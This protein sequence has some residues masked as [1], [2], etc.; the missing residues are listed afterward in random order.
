LQL[1]SLC[2][3]ANPIILETGKFIREQSQRLH[4]ITIEE[5]DINSLVSYV[6]REAEKQLVAELGKLLPD[7]GFLTEEDTPNTEGKTWQWI[8]D[9]LD[10]TTNFLYGIPCFS[11]SVGLK[12]DDKLVLG[13]IYEINDDEL[14]YAWEN[15]GAFLN[16]NRIHVSQRKLLSQ[17]LLATGF[18]YYDFTSMGKYLKSFTYLM[19]NSR[20]IRRLGSAA[21]DLAYVAC[22]RFDGFFEYS[23][24]P[25]DVAGGAVIVKE[26]GGSVIDF[27]GGENY[28]FGKEIIASNPFITKDLM[29]VLK[30]DFHERVDSPV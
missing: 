12:R 19:Q 5:K 21:V 9:P 13:I 24:N 20:G 15:G 29:K 16:K 30:K 3:K 14:F 18:P 1:E 6:D 22:G 2:E 27:T 17:S 25:W 26:A 28:L 23:L 8:I 10:G 7:A 11:I 4:E